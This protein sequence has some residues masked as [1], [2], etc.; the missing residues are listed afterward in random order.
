MFVCLLIGITTLIARRK[1]TQ[2]VADNLEAAACPTAV[3]VEVAVVVQ[4]GLGPH[5]PPP[6]VASRMAAAAP[7]QDVPLGCASACT[8]AGQQQ[9]WG[10]PT[11]SLCH[12]GAVRLPQVLA[13]EVAM[14]CKHNEASN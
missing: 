4:S 2:V 14:A 10:T 9:G 6:A 11:Q 1:G 7:R 12:T 13:Q 8:Q 3:A 5:T